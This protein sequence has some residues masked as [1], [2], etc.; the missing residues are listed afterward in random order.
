MSKKAKSPQPRLAL[1]PPP[2][3]L[4]PKIRYRYEKPSLN[5][6]NNRCYSAF[7]DKN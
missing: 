7:Q 5:F 3:S 4:F 1:Y 6:L 2:Q